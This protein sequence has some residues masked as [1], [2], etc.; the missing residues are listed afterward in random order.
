MENGEIICGGQGRGRGRRGG[1][2]AVGRGT[3]YG[4]GNRD[5][6]T[7]ELSKSASE[8]TTNFDGQRGNEGGRG[9]GRGGKGRHGREGGHKN[10][11]RGGRGHRGGHAVTK[12]NNVKGNNVKANKGAKDAKNVDKGTHGIAVDNKDSPVAYG[13]QELVMLV[14]DFQDLKASPEA[15]LGLVRMLGDRFSGHSLHIYSLYHE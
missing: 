6:K 2:R 13:L 5:P 4:N 11:G 1:G 9:R 8:A 7:A 12:G 14:N 10:H 3:K 15:D